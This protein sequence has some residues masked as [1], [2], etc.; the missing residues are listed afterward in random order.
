MAVRKMRKSPAGKP[1]GRCRKTIALDMDLARRLATYAAWHGKTES[2]V[3]EALLEARLSGVHLGWPKPCG[4]GPTRSG[5]A[6]A[7][8]RCAV[9]TL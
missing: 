4:D 5:E 6:R 2:A 3:V 8:G 7:N 9:R 1:A